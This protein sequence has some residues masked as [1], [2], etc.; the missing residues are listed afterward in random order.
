I[1][2]DLRILDNHIGITFDWYER[3]TKG[4]IQATSVPSTFGTGG[5]RVNAGNFRTRGYEISIDANY[6]IGKDIS[7]YATIGLNDYKTVFTKWDNPNNSVS[8]ALNYVG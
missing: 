7:L 8:N 5:P 4:M 2:A 3:N 6:D 1:G